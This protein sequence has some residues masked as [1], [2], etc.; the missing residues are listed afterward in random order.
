M[1]MTLNTISRWSFALLLLMATTLASAQ[2]QAGQVQ[3]VQG[4]AVAEQPGGPARPIDRGDALFVGDTVTT[5][6]KGF[7]VFALTDGGKITLRPNTSF[8]IEKYVLG[9]EEEHMLVRLLNGGLRT[10][11][12]LI[13]KRHPDKVEYHALTATLS[14]RGTSFDARLCEE[15]CRKESIADAPASYLPATIPANRVIARVVQAAGTAVAVHADHKERSLAEG[16]PLYTGDEVRTANGAWLVI[17]FRDHTLVSLEAET[18]FRIDT[19]TYD[20]REQSDSVAVSLMKGGLRYLTG[21]IGKKKP[22]A[23]SIGTVVATIGIRGTGIDTSCEGPCAQPLPD[24]ADRTIDAPAPGRNPGQPDRSDGL[25][26]LTWE[27]LIA[28]QSGGKSLDVDLERTGFV[29]ADQVATLLTDTPDFMR[30]FAAPRPDQIS[31]DW[32]ALFGSAG[33]EDS[34]AG[35]F[36]LVRD[37]GIL[38]SAAGEGIELGVGEAGYMGADGKPRRLDPVP[39]FMLNDLYPIPE[40]FTDGDVGIYQLLGVTMGV[41]GQDICEMR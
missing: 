22:S 1:N 12:G 10:V 36:V 2:Q 31:V 4:L 24:G 33:P 32:D 16:S 20:R 3:F 11:T 26:A 15:D 9:G 21:L 7:V 14:I 39:D 29:G 35:L 6:D 34:S 28:L 18:R 25:F 8:A 23:V 40:F 27:G 17:G 37:G 30:N 38:L 19:F 41:P 5:N 13:G